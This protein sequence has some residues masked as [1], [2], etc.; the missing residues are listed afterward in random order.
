MTIRRPFLPRSKLQSCSRRLGRMGWL[1]RT[2]W[3]PTGGVDRRIRVQVLTSP[4]PVDEDERHDGRHKDCG[5]CVQY[6][7]ESTGHERLEPRVSRRLL[8]LTVRRLDLRRTVEARPGMGRDDSP[9]GTLCRAP[10]Y[11]NKVRVSPRENAAWDS[12][13][14]VSIAWVPS[15]TPLRT[16]SIGFSANAT[17]PWLNVADSPRRSYTSRFCTSR[18]SHELYPRR[19]PT[20]AVHTRR[21]I[22]RRRVHSR[23]HGRAGSAVG[24]RRHAGTSR[25]CA[26][27]EA[28][29]LCIF[30]RPR[31]TSLGWITPG[32][33][34]SP[35]PDGREVWHY[36]P[37][38]APGRV[39]GGL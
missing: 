24:C 5:A 39:C 22:R 21:Q 6:V 11:V 23:V 9:L 29:R 36:C 17:A 35:L 2:V 16:D 1:P 27:S 31:H 15:W 14:P 38:S 28:R 34:L 10:R 3:N 7:V 8:S 13:K 33:S 20:Q 12:H 37:G 30:V 19:S 18:D 25:G 26:P 4:D 32:R